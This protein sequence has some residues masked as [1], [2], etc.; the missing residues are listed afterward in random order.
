V[1]K[2]WVAAPTG[3]RALV[4]EYTSSTRK[5]GRVQPKASFPVPLAPENDDGLSFVCGSYPSTAPSSE[6]RLIG[7]SR[8]AG[9][10]GGK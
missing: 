7:P 9:L 10:A 3:Q 6:E 1:A 5:A 8:S 2:P 4:S